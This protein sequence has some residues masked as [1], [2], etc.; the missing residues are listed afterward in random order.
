MKIEDY[1]NKHKRYIEYIEVLIPFEVIK[2][3]EIYLDGTGKTIFESSDNKKKVRYVKMRLYKQFEDK[4]PK[5]YKKFINSLVY[6]IV[7]EKNGQAIGIKI[8]HLGDV[9][10]NPEEVIKNE[11]H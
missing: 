10:L 6:D 4:I 8:T 11:S 5:L 7:Y 2:E 9:V 1:I 3:E